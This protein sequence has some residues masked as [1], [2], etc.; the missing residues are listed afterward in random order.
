MLVQY[1]RKCIDNLYPRSRN[2]DLPLTTIALSQATLGGGFECTLRLRACRRRVGAHGLPESFLIYS[3]AWSWLPRPHV[4]RTAH[5]PRGLISGNLYTARQLYDMGVVDVLAPATLV[6]LP[7]TASSRSTR[8]HRTAA[9]R[10]EMVRR[11]VEPS[12]TRVDARRR[13]LR[14]NAFGAASDGTRPV[15]ERLV[16]QDRTVASQPRQ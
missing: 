13:R 7:S 11:E 14:A 9:A 15:E 12:R 16:R 2:C 1:G 5:L 6:R 8:N 3:L 10:D 4:S